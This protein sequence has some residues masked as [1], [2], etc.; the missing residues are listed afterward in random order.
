MALSTPQM[1]SRVGGGPIC[2]D[3]CVPATASAGCPGVP[4][5][6]DWPGPLPTL[7]RTSPETCPSLSGQTLGVITG[8]LC[9]A[10]ALNMSLED[11]GSLVLLERLGRERERL[12]LQPY[13]PNPKPSPSRTDDAPPGARGAK[14]KRREGRK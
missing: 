6:G 3:C 5:V 1:I 8:G 7:R 10:P 13:L 4:D 2:G 12:G 14:G 11:T 9:S